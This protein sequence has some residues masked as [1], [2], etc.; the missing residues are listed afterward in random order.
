VAFHLAFNLINVLWLPVTSS[1][2]AFAWLVAAEW[3]L[4]VV[5]VPYLAPRARLVPAAAR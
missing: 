3:L 4:A 2:G 1:V 5:L